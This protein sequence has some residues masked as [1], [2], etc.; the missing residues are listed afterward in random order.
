M[1]DIIH[2]KNATQNQKI[3]FHCKLEDLSSLLRVWTAH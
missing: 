2:K 3:F 1:Y